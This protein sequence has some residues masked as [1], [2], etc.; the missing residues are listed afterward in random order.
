[1]VAF[2]ASL[3]VTVVMI[4]IVVAVGRRRAPGT[5]LTWGEAFGA[6]VYVFLLFVM[7]F[8]IVPNEWLLLA[9][10]TLGWRSDK[11]FW[12]IKNG[13]SF[14]GRGQILISAQVFR[15][16]IAAGIYGVFLVGTFVMWLW[17]QKR[18]AS[19]AAKQPELTSAYG[20]PLVKKV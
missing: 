16:I 9:D 6:A 2:I 20:R 3:V 13:V 12:F 18:G 14:G 17:W 5:P 19:T 4:G 15:D 11:F 10:N 7:I 1:M 8:G